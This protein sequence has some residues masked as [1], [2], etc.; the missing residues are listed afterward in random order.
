MKTILLAATAVL[1]TVAAAQAQST[2]NT[3]RI[4]A[5]STQIEEK[6]LDGSGGRASTTGSA[7][8]GSAVSDRGGCRE[9]SVRTRQSDATTVIRKFVRCD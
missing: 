9:V 2:N 6:I 5:N 8:T 3:S 7:T 1:L 4:Q